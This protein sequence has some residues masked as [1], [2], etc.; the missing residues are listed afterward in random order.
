MLLQDLLVAVVVRRPEQLAG[1]VET[2]LDPPGAVAAG[3]AVAGD[4]VVG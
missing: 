2:L 1:G 4:V 3:A